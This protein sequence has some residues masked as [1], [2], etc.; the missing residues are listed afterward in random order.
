MPRSPAQIKTSP[1][2]GEHNDYVYTGLLGIPDEE[3]VE[4]L[5]DGVFE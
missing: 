5:N 1:C 2:L 3:Y 4:L